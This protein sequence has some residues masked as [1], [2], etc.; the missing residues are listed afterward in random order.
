MKIKKEHL[1][2]AFLVTLSLFIF[3]K[4]T[5]VIGI[6][7]GNLEKDARVSQKIDDNWDVSKSTT[8]H[9]GAMLFYNNTHDEFI[10]SIYLNRPDFSFGY[11]FATGVVSGGI[12]DSIRELTYGSNGS[13]LISMN[14][15]KVAKI[16]L[17]NDS[18]VTTINIDSTKPFVVVL[19]CNY[20]EMTLFDLNGN[21]VPM[22][23]E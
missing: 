1:G 15:K 10:F 4:S 22:S 14:T 17:N 8:K 18:D 19:P 16:E 5:S 13:V 11:F 3:I 21:V 12:D 7:A 2:I 6:T 20:G 9:I 23:A